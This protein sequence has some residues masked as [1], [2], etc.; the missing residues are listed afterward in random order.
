MTQKRQLL[1]SQL[2]A[3]K[4]K[5]TE[6][7]VNDGRGLY[8]RVRPTGVKSFVLRRKVNGV[9]IRTTLGR[10]PDISLRR[11]RNL[12]GAERLKDSEKKHDL[13]N[14]LDHTH[15]RTFG[16]LLE[17]YYEV[18]IARDHKRPRQTRL[19]IDN[20]IP[21]KVKQLDI[22]QLSEFEA[23]RFR[24]GIQNWLVKYA[25]ESGPIGANR[26][27]AILKQATRHGV[28]AGKI[29]IDPLAP[30]TKKQVGGTEKPR[31]RTLTDEEI[32]ALWHKNSPHQALFQFLM[33]TGQRIGEAQ[34]ARWAH[35]VDNRWIIPA[36]NS[37]NA[38]AHWVPI[39]PAIQSILD[40]QPKDRDL[41]FASRST[42]GVQAWLRRWLMKQKMEDRY[43]PH[44]IR[45]TFVT[46]LNDL[47]ARPYVV[48]KM[49]NHSLSGV[50]A[51]YN[52]SEYD[53]ERFAAAEVWAQHLLA[54][55]EPGARD[56]Q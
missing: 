50:M 13:G 7:F 17:D 19:Y 56:E 53:E 8:I 15:I 41:I 54:I 37:K 18:Q 14:F 40:A 36:E 51:T 1:D 33:L 45:R 55:V 39:V 46:R 32:A 12:A 28:A 2:K 34:A 35:I 27:L 23:L 42:T 47:G 30:L 21:D 11:A 49:V 4:P 44:D 9:Q 25:R 29:L 43:T 48:E 6:F 22:A 26:L 3:I 10:Y 52:H 16:D 20:R 24:G 38:R 31:E 5:D